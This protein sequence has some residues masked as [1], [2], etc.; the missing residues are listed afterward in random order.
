MKQY[1]TYKSHGGFEIDINFLTGKSMEYKKAFAFIL[2]IKKAFKNS[3]VYNYSP[4]KL[5]EKINAS[6]YIT[7]KYINNLV[8]ADL[9]HFKGEHL[10]FISLNK[11]MHLRSRGAVIH[12]S[13]KSTIDSIVEKINILIIK[14]NFSKQDKLRTVKSD[15]INSKKKGAKINLKSYKKSLKFAEQ[16]PEIKDERLIDFNIIGMRKIAE[17][18]GSSLDYAARFILNLV[19]KK[20]IQIK[21]IVKKYADFSSIQYSSDELKNFINKKSGYFYSFKGCTYHYLGTE[22][23]FI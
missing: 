13:E 4:K 3:I 11:I 23:E 20:L 1:K 7:E 2:L 8:L 22:I 15:L 12:I 9:C 19:S 14:N 5:S 21:R 6:E 17:I 18:L 16:H 10:H